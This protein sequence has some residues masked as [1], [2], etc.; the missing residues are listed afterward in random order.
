M[1]PLDFLK[2]ASD[3]QCSSEE[4]GVRTAVGRAY[5]AIFNYVR[6]YLAENNINLPNHGI[7]Q[8]L[9]LCVKNSGV[10]GARDVGQTIDEL[11]ADRQE[12]DY[13]MESTRWREKTCELLV[14]KAGLAI[15]EFQK[16]EGQVFIS[17]ARDYLVN[18]KKVPV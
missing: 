12:V 13:E 17:G 18:V 9:Y 15:E 5:Y 10:N 16:C 3:L 2:I 1:D 11:R 14:L 4:A 7:H 8:N 6:A